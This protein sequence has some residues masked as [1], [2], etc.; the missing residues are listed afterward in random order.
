M[1]NNWWFLFQIK[2]VWYNKKL[3]DEISLNFPELLIIGKHVK[4]MSKNRGSPCSV[5]EVKRSK[6]LQKLDKRD[7]FCLHSWF[8]FLWLF[9][10]KNW[11][12]QQ[13]FSSFKFGWFFEQDHLLNLF[14]LGVYA[15]RWPKCARIS[16]QKLM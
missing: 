5:P 12:T 14:I 13:I 3:V 9:S 16:K 1:I 6:I 10:R 4:I 11:F 2:K 8:H 15:K 7:C